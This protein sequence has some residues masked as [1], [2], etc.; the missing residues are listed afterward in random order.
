[1][2]VA[3]GPGA[4]ATWNTN[5][6]TACSNTSQT[7]TPEATGN[8]HQPIN[9]VSWYE[10]YAF[11]IWDGGFLPSEAEWEYAAAGG[12]QQREFPWGSA[13]PTSQYSSNWVASVPFVVAPVGAAALGAGLWGQLDMDS[14]LFEWNLDYSAAYANPCTNCADLA[15]AYGRVNRGGGPPVSPLEAF[16]PSYR[17]ELDPAAHA[18]TDGFRCARTP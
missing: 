8:E 15:P 3:T 6:T 2:Y 11:C 13:E 12:S 9:C 18:N 10:A 4:A 7:W 5:L 16:L 1:V 17:N 14:Q